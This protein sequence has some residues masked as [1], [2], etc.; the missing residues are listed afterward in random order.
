M[1]GGAAE[2]KNLFKR[3]ETVEVSDEIVGGSTTS[4][5]FAL[6]LHRQQRCERVLELDTSWWQEVQI[7][8]S[9]S[10]SQELGTSPGKRSC[11][12]RDIYECISSR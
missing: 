12:R 11:A 1:Q 3:W 4:G 7:D 5:V 8:R 10:S 2:L 9:R 6:N